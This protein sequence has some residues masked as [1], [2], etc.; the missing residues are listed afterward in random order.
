VKVCLGRVVLFGYVLL[1][2]IY[3]ITR[4]NIGLYMYVKV[5]FFCSFCLLELYMW[6]RSSVFSNWP[7]F[8]VCS[9]SNV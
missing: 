2:W 8:S 1:W 3:F 5:P 7:F 6:N 4:P 9:I